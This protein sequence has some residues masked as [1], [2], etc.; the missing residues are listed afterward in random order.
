M[1]F[2]INQV[3]LGIGCENRPYRSKVRIPSTRRVWVRRQVSIRRKVGINRLSGMVVERVFQSF[4]CFHSFC[5]YDSKSIKAVTKWLPYKGSHSTIA[6]EGPLQHR[7]GYSDQ[8]SKVR[9]L[10]EFYR[11]H[12]NP[13]FLVNLYTFFFL[14]RTQNQPYMPYVTAFMQEEFGNRLFLLIFGQSY[15]L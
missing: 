15:F 5:F 14:M 12:P 4:S 6:S 1:N 3:G 10:L 13:V 8:T 9:I 2:S 11:D 7:I